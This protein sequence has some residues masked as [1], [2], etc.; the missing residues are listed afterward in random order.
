MRVEHRL[1]FQR[2]DLEAGADDQ[3]LAAPG[4]EQGAV[5]ILARQVAG[6][7][8]AARRSTAAVLRLAVVALH[9]V[10]AAHEQ[11]RRSAAGGQSFDPH[12]DA[13]NRMADRGVGARRIEAGLADRG[14]GFG[15]A[16]AVVQRG[17]R[18]GLRPRA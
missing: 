15:Q 2:I 17:R 1:D 9:H 13:R 12:F 10:R 4:D 6:I 3:L 8:P 18:A 16:V 14:R 7:E 11:L 5:R